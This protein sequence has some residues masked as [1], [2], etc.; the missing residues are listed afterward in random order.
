MQEWN[1]LPNKMNMKEVKCN[2]QVEWQ[3]CK[4]FIWPSAPLIIPWQ[5]TV[6]DDDM[7]SLSTMEIEEVN[8]L[9]GIRFVATYHTYYW[10]G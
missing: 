9:G 5:I 4:K 1:P 10:Q 7:A 6:D 8:G 2:V 3:F